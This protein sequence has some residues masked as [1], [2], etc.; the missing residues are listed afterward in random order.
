MKYTYFIRFTMGNKV[1]DK[2]R[3][4]YKTNTI[5]IF[6]TMNNLLSP[7]HGMHDKDEER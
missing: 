7:K 4:L 6:A 3:N 2:R 5:E 1:P